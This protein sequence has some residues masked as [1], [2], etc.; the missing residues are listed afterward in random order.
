MATRTG[1]ED[2]QKVVLSVSM[3]LVLELIGIRRNRTTL[4]QVPAGVGKYTIDNY[5]YYGY[6]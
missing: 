6:Y 1:Q 4:A 2:T 3:R 5:Y